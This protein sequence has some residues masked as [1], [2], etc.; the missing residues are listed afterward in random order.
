MLQLIGE[1]LTE[2]KINFTIIGE[3][4]SFKNAGG[5]NR[6]IYN[7]SW[8][9]N[10]SS[11]YLL[12]KDKFLTHE[13]LISSKVPSIEQMLFTINL[14]NFEG[15]TLIDSKNRDLDKSVDFQAIYDYAEKLDFKLVAKPNHGSLGINVYKVESKKELDLVLAK[16][17]QMNYLE[18]NISRF[19]EI[20]FEF[21][22]VVLNG[23]LELI[24][25][26]QKL[27]VIGDGK[28]SVYD[29]VVRSYL[30]VSNL[31]MKIDELKEVLPQNF[32]KELDF[33]NNLHQGV[34]PERLDNTHVLWE[35]LGTIAIQ[36]AEILGLNFCS[37]DI[38]LCTDNQLRVIEVNSGI[39]FDNFYEQ[40]DSNK[41]LVR[42]IF[43]KAI[44]SIVNDKSQLV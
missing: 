37:V 28:L 27:K 39:M 5:V 2:K 9:N 18:V 30:K 31:K 26:K 10:S 40:S 21:R 38:I 24:Y 34:K 11:S 15:D 42:S 12:A 17:I 22:C 43:S 33:R 23:K 1:I 41:Q 36:S 20:A 6:I 4:L 44:D 16:F 35:K 19:E 14:R 32:E 25:S 3:A 29:L 13:F 7:K 8:A